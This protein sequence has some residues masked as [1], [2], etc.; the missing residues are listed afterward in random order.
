M[1][2]K[3]KLTVLFLITISASSFAQISTLI[4]NFKPAYLSGKPSEYIEEAENIVRN[5]NAQDKTKGKRILTLFKVL[6]GEQQ[7]MNTSDFYSA[8]TDVALSVVR[9]KN[10]NSD[11]SL[12][13]IKFGGYRSYL[14]F[15]Q[16]KKSYRFLLKGT[17]R[18]ATKSAVQNFEGG[19]AGNNC[20]VISYTATPFTYSVI[21]LTEIASVF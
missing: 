14:V 11:L 18:T 4:D 2:L 10:L 6:T 8:L 17:F 15:N 5:L 19:V 21:S 3:L 13:C 9:E 20:R 16:S 7:D 12:N 1:N